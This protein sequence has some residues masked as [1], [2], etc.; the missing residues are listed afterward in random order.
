MNFEDSINAIKGWSI[1]LLK[2]IEGRGNPSRVIDLAK[3]INAEGRKVEFRGG[4]LKYYQRKF[5][6]FSKII[7]VLEK[8]L[9]KSDCNYGNGVDYGTGFYG[10]FPVHSHSE[11][12]V[13]EKKLSSDVN[14]YESRLRG[15]NYYLKRVEE[16]LSKSRALAQLI[17]GSMDKVAELKKGEKDSDK[18]KSKTEALFKA[19][20]RN[21]A[22]IVDFFN[23]TF[24]FEKYIS[25][26]EYKDSGTAILPGFLHFKKHLKKCK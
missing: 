4:G 25:I 21:A 16:L 7:P 19:A 20:E 24:D 13:V 2:E 6:E 18:L 12:S 17:V 26:N 22:L 5:E 23:R 1:E 8:H 10:Q 9:K 14:N 3:K 15:L 11:L